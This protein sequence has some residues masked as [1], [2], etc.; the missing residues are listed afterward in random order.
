MSP[1]FLLS[2]ALAGAV[3]EECNSML[4]TDLQRASGMLSR[5]DFKHALEQGRSSKVIPCIIHQT[6][7]THTLKEQEAKWAQTWKDMN[8]KCEYK[9][10]NDTEI[11]ELAQKVSPKIIWPIWEGLHPVQRADVFRY[12]VLWHQGGYYADVDVSC[13]KPID[14]YKL[15]EATNMIVG[16]EFGHRFPEWQRAQIKFA[17]TE[18]FQ[19]WFIASAPGNPVLRRCLELIR[20]RYTWKVES[21]LELTGPGV[22]SDAVHEFLEMKSPHAVENEVKIR[23]HPPEA[24]FLSYPSESLFGYGK[25][26]MWVFAA[27]RVN[28]APMIAADDP[29]EGQENLVEHHFAGSWKKEEDLEDSQKKRNALSQQQATESAKGS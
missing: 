11:A 19:Q 17:R 22:F 16:Y 15:P 9:L 28:A 10:W 13:K 25:W 24:H 12:L 2:L 1:M 26:K 23:R 8:P 27:G 7:K 20:Q 4:M 6:A 21:T 18:Q 5:L 29:T 14:Q 3:A